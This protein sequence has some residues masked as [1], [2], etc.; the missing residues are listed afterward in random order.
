MSKAITRMFVAGLLTLL[1]SLA[2]STNRNC[3][4]QWT[5]N[6]NNPV[7]QFSQSLPGQ[8]MAWND[9]SVIKDGSIY[10]M[11]FSGGILGS[12]PIIQVYEASSND[13]ATWTINTTPIVSP[14]EPGSWDD[15]RIETPVVIKIASNNYHLYYSGC[16]VTGCLVPQ[17]S[18]GHATSV[19]G[20]TWI[21]DPANPVITYQTTDPTQWS[22]NGVGEPGAVW[23]PAQQLI[24]LYYSSAKLRPGY[25]GQDRQDLGWMEGI[26]L[27][28]SSDGTNFTHYDPA[29]NGYDE[30]VLTQSTY[31]SVQQLYVG[32]ST[33]S[34]FIDSKNTFHLFYDVARFPQPGLWV[35][36]ALAHA[37]SSDGISY[38][39]IETGIYTA[40]GA[41][42]DNWFN[43]EVRSPTVIQDGSLFKMWFAGTGPN[44]NWLEGGI[45]Y[46]TGVYNSSCP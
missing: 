21:K 25:T 41:G 13:G 6:P 16:S 1:S 33:P 26:A 2:S 19:D 22:Y 39:E 28:T 12:N 5:Q 14:G 45:G 10:R 42:L 15:Q 17:Y 36:V 18:I 43:W 20:T 3:T 30:A 46:A 32:Y 40:G 44:N 24:Y 7:I 11:W 8:F 37:T 9:P 31:Y 38:S 23:N 29:H 4:G 34:A 35:Q 27:A